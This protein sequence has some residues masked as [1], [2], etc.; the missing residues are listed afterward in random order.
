MSTTAAS[1]APGRDALARQAH[2][3]FAGERARPGPA[4]GERAQR[5]VA[6]D[7]AGASTRSAASGRRRRRAPLE[8]A[9]VRGAA[10]GGGDAARRGRHERNAEIAGR[11]RP[12][13]AAAAAGAPPAHRES[14]VELAHSSPARRSSTRA[15]ISA[16][17]R[18]TAGAQVTATCRRRENEADRRGEGNHRARPNARGRR[19]LPHPATSAPRFAQGR[20]RSTQTIRSRANTRHARPLPKCDFGQLAASP[21]Q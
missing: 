19:N 20:V 13:A 17:S 3:A 5:R 10:C 14:F 11:D 6:V 7:A 21:N 2:L 16:R 15:D 12:R 18:S 1:S 9:G 8:L 4:A